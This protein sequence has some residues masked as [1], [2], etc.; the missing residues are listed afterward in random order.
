MDGHSNA[1]NVCCP[2]GAGGGSPP[3]EV[4]RLFAHTRKNCACSR[5]D[6][7]MSA[8]VGSACKAW[9]D[10]WRNLP[11]EILH[12]RRDDLHQFDVHSAQPKL[13]NS[14]DSKSPLHSRGFSYGGDVFR[15]S[16]KYAP[17]HEWASAKGAEPNTTLVAG[18]ISSS[19]FG[20]SHNDWDVRDF[21]DYDLENPQIG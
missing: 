15:H 16:Y 19:H 1:T 6:R 9:L 8:R 18:R 10:C 11:A 2:V 4:S 21:P 7:A 14:V 12:T 20:G 5:V 3:G 13:A 17:I